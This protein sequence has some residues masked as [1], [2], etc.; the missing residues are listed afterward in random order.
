MSAFRG[1]A[2][3]YSTAS[4]SSREGSTKVLDDNVT[5]MK[6]K[7]SISFGASFIQANVWLKN[8]QMRADASAWAS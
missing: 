7:H 1:I 8:Q 6:G 4:N 5:W 3:P 2:N